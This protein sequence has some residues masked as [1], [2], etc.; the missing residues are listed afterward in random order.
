MFLFCF[1]DLSV[2]QNPGNCPVAFALNPQFGGSRPGARCPRIVLVKLGQT[3]NLEQGYFRVEVFRL[4]VRLLSD[5]NA[6][7]C[8][9]IYA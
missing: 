1:L 8:A 5:F 3:Q 6:T 9:H 2:T 4:E 7:S